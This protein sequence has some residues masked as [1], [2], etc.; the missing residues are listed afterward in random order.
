M[1]PLAHWIKK[2]DLKPHPE[3]GFF[4][5]TYR[6]PENYTGSLPSRYE[7]KRSFG[8]A[9]Y[10]MIT[11]GNPSHFHRLKSDELWFFHDGSPLLVHLLKEDGSYETLAI[12]REQDW[13]AIIPAGTWFAAEVDAENSYSLI[14]CTVAPGF[15]FMDFEM[16]KENDLLLSYPGQSQLI[17]RLCL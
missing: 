16:A 13:Q 15:D 5:E 3:G 12:G 17:S 6:S 9:I 11:S 14:S 7:G 10:F 1:K 8:T 2:L 4:K